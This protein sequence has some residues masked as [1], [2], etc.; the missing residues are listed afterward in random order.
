VGV[1]RD[2]SAAMSAPITEPRVLGRFYVRRI[3][4]V[5]VELVLCVCAFVMSVTVIL[6]IRATSGVQRPLCGEGFDLR[7]ALQTLSK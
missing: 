1:V 6:H 5:F 4:L 7:P 2:A 3:S